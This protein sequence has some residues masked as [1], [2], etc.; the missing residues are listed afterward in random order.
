MGMVPNNVRGIRAETLPLLWPRSRR[1]RRV[2]GMVPDAV[3]AAV[4]YEALGAA[5]GLGSGVHITSLPLLSGDLGPRCGQDP[6][7]LCLLW[8]LRH[9]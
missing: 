7:P 5:A 2:E 1:G 6:P 3:G 8:S 4:T 9:S